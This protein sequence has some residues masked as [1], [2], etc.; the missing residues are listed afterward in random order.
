MGGARD[1]EHTFQWGRYKR[2]RFNPCVR[3]IPLEE[4][5]AIHSSILAWG[6]PWTEEHGRLSRTESDMTE[7]T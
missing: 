1:K 2:G 6:I 4:G 3:K 7:A 5:M